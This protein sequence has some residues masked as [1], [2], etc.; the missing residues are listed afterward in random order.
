[1]GADFVVVELL[2]QK[3]RVAFDADFRE[4]DKCG[5]AAV[6]VYGIHRNLEP[7]ESMVASV[8][9]SVMYGIGPPRK[10]VGIEC[11]GTFYGYASHRELSL[12]LYH[13]RLCCE[14]RKTHT[15]ADY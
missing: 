13:Q 15:R 4:C 9:L 7:C 6:T 11:T 5:V 14:T 10:R 3:M 2:H 8:G 1:M 12:T